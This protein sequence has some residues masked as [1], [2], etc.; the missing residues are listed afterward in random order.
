MSLLAAVL[1]RRTVLDELP[2]T[3]DQLPHFFLFSM[4]FLRK[5]SDEFGEPGNHDRID[6]IGLCQ[7]A[8]SPCEISNLPR[9]GRRDVMPCG[10]HVTNKIP[11][12]PARRLKDDQARS[13]GRQQ[14]EELAA[15]CRGIVKVTS[16]AFCQTG[17]IE[18]RLPHIDPN[19]PVIPL[20]HKVPF[21]LMRTRA[22]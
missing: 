12:I 7:D 2:T 1:F 21:L 22:A 13:H 4:V 17:N 14:P 16:L 9:I 6:P 3:H 20:R 15:A 5:W 18:T 19:E 10:H 11:L 8:K